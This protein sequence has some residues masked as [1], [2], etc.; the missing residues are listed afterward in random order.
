MAPSPNALCFGAELPASGAA[1]FAGLSPD[2]L[3]VMFLPDRGGEVHIIPFPAL[4]VGAGG[5]DHDQLVLKWTDRGRA[6]ALHSRDPELIREL[7]TSAPAALAAAL[8]HTTN[9]VRRRR[10]IRW[11]AWVASIALLVGGLT[12]LWYGSEVLVDLIV[13]RIPLSWE[14]SLGESAYRQFLSGQTVVREGPAVQA[15][16]ALADRLTSHIAGSPYRFQVTVVESGVVNAFA[17]PGGYIVVFTGLLKKA[18]GPE[19]VAGV[20]GH[21][22]NHVLLRHAMERIV[23]NLGLVAVVTVLTGNQHGLGGVMKELGIEL[24]TL[25]FGREQE[26][27]AD[28]EGLR[29]LHRAKVSPEGMIAFFQRLADL[30]GRQVELLSTHPMSEARAERIRAE[31]AALPRMI[32]EPFAIDWY[33]VQAAVK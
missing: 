9:Q 32:P 3:A 17:L 13:S 4:V 27:E 22:L 14:E 24:V 31:A 1:C 2:G 26:L 33:A 21:E 29:L 28:L 23:K 7:R 15:V 12:W 11:L 25:K 10:T 18:A 16:Q 19:E 30:N 8:G 5:F 20:L 6:F